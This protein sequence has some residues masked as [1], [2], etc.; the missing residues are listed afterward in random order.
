MSPSKEDI[1]TILNSTAYFDEKSMRIL[2]LKLENKNGV[3]PEVNN[4]TWS[5]LSFKGDE[6]I[7]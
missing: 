4:F 5:V 1:E 6:L 7:L 2:D 3:S